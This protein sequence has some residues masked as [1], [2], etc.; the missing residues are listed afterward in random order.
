MWILVFILFGIFN[1]VAFLIPK[2][3]SKIEIYAT[4]FF[5]YSYGITTDIIL[6]LHYHLY[7]YFGKGFQW[8]S[9]IAIFMYFPAVSII[10]LNLYPSNGNFA[11]KV[12][13]IIYWTVFSIAF[14]WF[15]VHTKFFYYN[16]WKLWYSAF[17]YP[18]IFSVLLINL[19]L[20]RKLLE[21]QYVKRC[22]R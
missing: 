13:N 22:P 18:I 7:G 8:L 5:A 16:E 14:E 19:K 10:F 4:S 2:R 11:K 9:L 6:D 3:L 20:V 21:K 1:V 12:L 17:C 15:T